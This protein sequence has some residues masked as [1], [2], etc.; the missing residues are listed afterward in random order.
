MLQHPEKLLI[1]ESAVHSSPVQFKDVVPA[2]ALKE[3]C[4]CV[5]VF[6]QLMLQLGVVTFVNTTSQFPQSL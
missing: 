1:V 5:C 6:L 3:R 2:R 4:V